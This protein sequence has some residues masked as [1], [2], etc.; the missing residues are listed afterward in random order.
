[1]MPT[2]DPSPSPGAVHLPAVVPAHRAAVSGALPATLASPVKLEPIALLN[3]LRRRWPL[4]LGAGLLCAAVAAGAAYALVPTEKYTARAMLH[5]NSV[6]PRILLNVREVY[7]D[8]G[9]YQ[10]TQLALIKSRLVLNAALKGEYVDSRGAKHEVARLPGIAQHADPIEWLEQELQVDFANGSEILRI[11]MSSDEAEE[12]MVLVNAVTQAY[13]DEVVDV[14]TKQRR[15]RF[16]L[17]KET[18]N[19]Y[20]ENL[21]E[22]RKELKR[23]T[24]VAGSDDKKTLASLQQHGLDRLGRAEDELAR[25]ETELR[26]LSV[27]YEVLAGEGDAAAATISPAMIEDEIRKDSTIEAL[28]ER[29]AQAQRYLE[30]ASRLARA[31]SDPSVQ[32]FR[33]ELETARAAITAQ[34]KKLYPLIARQLQER[35]RGDVGTKTALLQKQIKILTKIRDALADDVKRLSERNVKL[36][37]DTVDLF[38]IQEEISHADSVA[39]TIGS[40][41]EA[42]NVELQAPPRIRLLENAAL[43]RTKDETRPLKMAWMAGCGAFAFVLVGISFWEFRARRIDSAD[44]VVHHLGM[45]V[46]GTLPVL[47]ERSRLGSLGEAQTQ[48]LRNL[49]IESVDAARTTLLHVSRTEGVRVVMIASALGGEGKT[50]LTAHLA[51]S[52]ARSGRRT[53][54]IDGDLR[55]PS[56]HRLFDLP[57]EPGLCEVLRGEVNLADVA[58]PALAN[59]LW[60]IPAGHCDGVA[61][62]ALASTDLRA[63]LDRLKEQFDFIVIDSSP[64]LPVA[65]ALLIG[66][67]VDAVL[68]S[69]MRDVSRLP[70]VHAA[71]ERLLSLGIRLLGAIVTGAQGEPYGT[72]YL[73]TFRSENEA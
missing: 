54:L 44:E 69:I 45:R 35:M 9:A 55:R 30:Q 47:P 40:E 29:A 65:D 25:V 1:M 60:L 67:H 8:Y 63:M 5:V 41:V 15:E 53:L 4:A 52:L 6:P 70:K 37:R 43:P 62:Q 17:L 48:R 31:G 49:L 42:L 11:S 26:P 13:R 38:S 2:S 18:W 33:N 20:Q 50:S 7:P 68:F 36:T 12:P 64:V 56:A 59:G 61:V 10:R 66:Q 58:Q 23:L 46:V 3:A 21:R 71:Y 57:Q 16:D 19:R 34:R 51:T 22:K 72:D 32:R 73:Y 28:V 39:Q 14:E 27:E 24:E